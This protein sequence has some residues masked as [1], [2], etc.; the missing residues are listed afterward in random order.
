MYILQIMLNVET[1]DV[2][3]EAEEAVAL[4]LKTISTVT[5]TRVK[6][7]VR[8]RTHINMF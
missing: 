6:M 4:P 8:H 5:K 7:K 3:D 1:D 2:P